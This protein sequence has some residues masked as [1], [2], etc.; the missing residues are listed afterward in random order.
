MNPKRLL[1]A[2]AVWL[3]LVAG[4]IGGGHPALGG[5]TAALCTPF[6]DPPA[7]VTG[8]VKPDCLHGDI[9]GPWKDANGNNRYACLWEPYRASSSRRLPMVIY[10]H[11]SLAGPRSISKTG[12]LL[13]Q[14]DTS[15]SAG[16]SGYIVMAPVARKTLHHYPR[17]D[18]K[19]LG[20]DN[21][22]RQ[23]SPAGSVIVRDALYRENADA[24]AI[25]HFVAQ[26]LA[27][28]K[29]DPARIYITGWSNG[30]AM[31]YLY[32]LN[33]PAIAAVAVYSAPDPFGAFDDPCPQTPVAGPPA[34]DHQVQIFNPGVPTMHLH[35]DCDVA[36]ICPNGELM[37]RQLA[38]AGVAVR[39]TIIDFAGTQVN[40]CSAA[41]GSSDRADASL[42]SNPLGYSLG[43]VRHLRWPEKWTP[44][45]LAFLRSHPL[46][47]AASNGGVS[48]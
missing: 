42:T 30:A 28:G 41:C 45:M 20:W 46:A 40:Q 23:L 33:R 8:E 25:D 7:I 38:G 48:R 24:A 43:F 29:V 3:A 21:W 5:D 19:G 17:P 16:R 1:S 2:L 15:L 12:L 31:A 14:D 18:E 11:P 37:A 10:L 27:T 13:Y 32:G 36:G 6:G 34:N 39:D 22:Y 44:V 9:L 35:N 26:E 4:A 47:T